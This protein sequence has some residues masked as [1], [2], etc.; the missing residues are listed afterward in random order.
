[1]EHLSV[2]LQ[3]VVPLGSVNQVSFGLRG[4]PRALGRSILMVVGHGQIV[5]PLKCCGLLKLHVLDLHLLEVL[6]HHFLLCLK[7]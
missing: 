1:M 4:H 2:W 3:V 5:L 7:S 6:L